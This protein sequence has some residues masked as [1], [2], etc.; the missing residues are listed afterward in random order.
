M[1]Q[2]WHRDG[3]VLTLNRQITAEGDSSFGVIWLHD[4]VNTMTVGTGPRFVGPGADRDSFLEHFT[5]VP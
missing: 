5:V 1:F 4:V 3:T 2:W